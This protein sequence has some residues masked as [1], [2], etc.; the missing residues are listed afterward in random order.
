M[1]KEA[2]RLVEYNKRKEVVESL[3]WKV[4]HL[5]PQNESMQLN[6]A[7]AK[8]L[9]D[10]I[11]KILPNVTN[12]KILHDIL[13][14]LYKEN[15]ETEIDII[16]EEKE[17]PS[18]GIDSFKRIFYS[19]SDSYE[20]KME[21]INLLK[22]G[23]FTVGD[24]DTGKIIKLGNLFKVTNTFIE[25][26]VQIL[27]EWI[28]RMGAKSAVGMGEAFLVLFINGAKKPTKGDFF[29]GGTAYEVKSTKKA[30]GSGGG[31]LA[32]MSGYKPDLTKHLELF[33]SLLLKA[34]ME[35]VQSGARSLNLPSDPNTYNF[36]TTFK[37]WN[38]ML[39]NT[40]EA[41][42]KIIEELMTTIYYKSKDVKWVD[43]VVGKDGKVNSDFHKYAGIH[44]ARSYRNAEKFSK[45]IW[46]NTNS[47]TIL[48]TDISQTK[49]N[50][51]NGNIAVTGTAS[52][53][54]SGSNTYR[55]GLAK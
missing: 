43:K 18:G 46:F 13:N 12:I 39:P 29:Y 10:D 32:G 36:K 1:F 48:V 5:K 3:M 9:M 22:N 49:A 38:D 30:N 20:N 17:I 42:V 33:K 24:I 47:D 21:F 19:V 25:E 52:F 8:G 26:M 54:D 2:L 6:E 23:A 41:T 16:L 40:K 27:M 34:N 11:K 35:E 28:P 31:N 15:F 14:R 53:K 50:I 37:D 51:L 7:D 45:Y 55:F 4:T 44:M